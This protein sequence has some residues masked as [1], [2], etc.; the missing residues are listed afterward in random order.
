[1]VRGSFALDDGPGVGKMAGQAPVAKWRAGQIS[2]ALWSNEIDVNGKT[3]TILKASVQRRYKDKDG[4]WQSSG[5]FARNEI[6]LAVYCLQQAFQKIIETQSKQS[7]DN[8][9]PDEGPMYD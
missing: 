6:P 2:S 9:S 7:N 3:V 4:N 1:M 8:N 5:S